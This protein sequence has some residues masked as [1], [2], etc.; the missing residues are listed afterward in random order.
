MRRKQD[1]DNLLA[2]LCLLDLVDIAPILPVASYQLMTSP[3]DFGRNGM[4][5][6]TT[7]TDSPWS[8]PIPVLFDL[9]LLFMMAPFTNDTFLSLE[10]PA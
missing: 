7:P 8:S 5:V 6:V 9:L 1:G 3:E 4:V 10:A 2:P